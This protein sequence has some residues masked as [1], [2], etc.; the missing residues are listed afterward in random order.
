MNSNNTLF[1][2]AMESNID[3]YGI[4]YGCPKKSRG[5]DCPLSE[6]ES[7]SFKE[8][9]ARIEELADEKKKSILTYHASCTKRME[10]L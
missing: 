8:R 2:N 1:L 6:I 10:V 5:K 9:I 3:L 7:L 4:A